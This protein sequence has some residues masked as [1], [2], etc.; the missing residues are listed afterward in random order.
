MLSLTMNTVNIKAP[1]FYRTLDV[2]LKYR[3]VILFLL[4]FFKVAINAT[5][6]IW[7]DDFWE[8]TADIRAFMANPF[9]PGHPQFLSDDPHVFL[10]PFTFL[11]AMFGLAIGSDPII[12]LALFSIIN[13]CLLFLGLY[14]FISTVNKNNTDSICFYSL[15]LI[16]FLSGKNPWQFS[17]FF[18]YQI[19]LGVLPLPSTFV[20][21][22]SLIGLYANYVRIKEKR[23]YLFFVLVIIN[24]VSIL[25]HPL[26]AIFLFSG[27]LAQALVERKITS[28][29]EVLALFVISILGASFWPYFSI[30][31]LM[32]SG[33]NIYHVLNISLYSNIFEKIWPSLLL[34]PLL[35]KSFLYKDNRIIITTF[36]ILVVIY[37]CG[38]LFQKYA[39]GR[40]ISFILI[41]INILVA[42]VIVNYE[43][44]TKFKHE[45]FYYS[46]QFI[47]LLI[48]LATNFSWI[49]ESAQR[50]LTVLNSIRLERAI[51]NQTTF[52][53][54]T[55]LTNYAKPNDLIIADLTSS[56]II[57]AFSGKVIATL[58][59]D[60]MLKDGEERTNDMVKFFDYNAN[61][62][63]RCEII[64][65]Y[66]PE[67][68][69]LLNKPDLN[70]LP[71]TTQFGS[72]GGG[73]VAYS[74]S[75][76]TLIK[77]ALDESCK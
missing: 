52:A 67:F 64:R 22:I 15:L 55:F 46:I 42:Q 63:R 16:L 20:M 2:I 18:N 7:V 32:S 37:I 57:P 19:F 41:L 3:L 62:E 34:L 5:N 35:S 36:F 66:N 74:N 47:F 21:G 29:I 48:L 24:I 40:T 75:K 10:N 65:K 4:I 73:F 23:Q 33:G 49:K 13:Y 72:L 30:L 12:S 11:V 14:L 69:F 68:L 45:F 8:H 56:W 25:S 54:Y 17:G 28:L 1:I 9:K 61:N 59:P 31:N 39:F 71:L 26:T 51:F 6:G 76:F 60:P 44:L 70:Y 27:I 77:L 58:L 43:K 50:S 38:Y 53:E